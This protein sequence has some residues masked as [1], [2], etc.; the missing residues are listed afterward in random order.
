[1]ES[2]P[3]GVTLLVD[4]TVGG[5]QLLGEHG[6]AFWIQWGL[7]RILFDTGQGLTL[8]NNA[9]RLGAPLAKVDAVVLSHGHYDHTGGLAGVLHSAPHAKVY[10]HPAAF[11]PKYSRNDDRTSRNIGSPLTEEQVRQRA[12]AWIPTTGLTEVCPGLFATGPIPRTTDFE[13]TGGPFFLD[14]SCQHGD[15]LVDDQAIFFEAVRGVVVLLGCAH[16]GVINT[17]RY[18]HELTGGK[19]IHAV[20]GGMHLRSASQER[21]SRTIQALR[22]FNVERLG[23]AHCTGMSASAQMWVTFPERCFPCSV[24]TTVKFNVPFVPADGEFS[25][26]RASSQ[27][28]V[29]P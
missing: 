10:A 21:V 8:R 3:A 5:R 24:G 25:P 17:L 13:E 22:R 9:H 2:Q 14:K 11:A 26:D 20:I 28:R 23:P 19:A 12:G 18:I 6:L 29:L 27:D 15:P 16:A 7:D 1:M 4:N